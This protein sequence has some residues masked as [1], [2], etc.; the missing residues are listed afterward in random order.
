MM[1]AQTAAML[2][3]AT[4]LIIG[5]AML[6][7]GFRRVGFLKVAIAAAILAIVLALMARSSPLIGPIAGLGFLFWYGV[8]RGSRWAFDKLSDA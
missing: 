8:G 1:T 2:G 6:V 5:V 3:Q 4:G 7:A